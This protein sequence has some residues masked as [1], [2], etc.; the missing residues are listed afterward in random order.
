MRTVQSPGLEIDDLILIL[1]IGVSAFVR[2]EYAEYNP[3]KIVLVD[4]LHKLPVIVSGGRIV[5][6]KEAVADNARIQKIL[7]RH[8]IVVLCGK[9]HENY[10][11]IGDKKLP[12]DEHEIIRAHRRLN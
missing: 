11:I 9:G 3:E 12:F 4:K 6:Y 8:D 2:S 7:N 1:C 10:Q 5:D